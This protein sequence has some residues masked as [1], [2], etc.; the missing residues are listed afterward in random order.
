MAYTG[1]HVHLYHTTA[2]LL[3]PVALDPAMARR[4]TQG[5]GVLWCAHGGLLHTARQ[6]ASGEPQEA[7]G[8][9][10]VSGICAR[11]HLGSP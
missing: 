5:D 1:I 6:C 8:W 11:I 10:A 3:V 7:G 4:T 2:A 9:G